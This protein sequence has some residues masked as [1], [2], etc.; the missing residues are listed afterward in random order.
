MVKITNG[1]NVY[2]VTT[3]AYESI[4]RHQ[5]YQVVNDKGQSDFVVD[6]AKVSKKTADEI[7]IEELREKPIAQWNKDEVRRYAA[8]EGIDLAGTKNINEAKEVIKEVMEG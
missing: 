2:E 5:G 6:P 8:L 3:G 1:A 7:F 4:Y